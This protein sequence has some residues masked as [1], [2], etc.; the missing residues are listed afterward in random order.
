MAAPGPATPCPPRRKR[1]RRRSLAVPPP[2]VRRRDPESRRA[3]APALAEPVRAVDD[4]GNAAGVA[5]RVR[6]RAGRTRPCDGGYGVV[7]RGYGACGIRAPTAAV[8][9]LP[10]QHVHGRGLVVERGRDGDA[11]VTR[12]ER[13][14]MDAC[15]EPAAK[16][17][18]HLAVR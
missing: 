18:P 10:H 6:R 11:L 1:A 15:L 13:R 3:D 8:T 17:L 14:P 2:A 9:C 16:M 7:R 5:L 12:R 4:D